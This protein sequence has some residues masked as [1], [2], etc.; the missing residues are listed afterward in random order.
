MAM[1]FAYKQLSHASSAS[2]LLTENQVLD[3]N[4]I[5]RVM[6]EGLILLGWCSL[7]PSQRALRWRAFSLV[8]DYRTIKSRGAITDS[9]TQ[10]KLTELTERLRDHP[11]LYTNAA[12]RTNS[13][14]NSDPY[15]KTWHVQESGARVE[16]RQMAEE[17]QDPTLKLLYD[18]LSQIAHWTPAGVGFDIRQN[19]EKPSIGFSSD[20]K[21]A[22]AYAVVFLALTQTLQ[23]FNSHFS[24]SHSANPLQDL[25]EKYSRD[26]SMNP[27]G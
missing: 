19:D 12:R 22:Q 1:C 6:L 2:M 15:Q 10:A 5:S 23:I 8:S 11:E 17:L 25:V 24:K 27:S 16:L 3:A 4:V 9:M 14:S 18:D 13:E 7:E 26:F 21:M 20:A